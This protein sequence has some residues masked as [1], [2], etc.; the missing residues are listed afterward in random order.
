M[1]PFDPNHNF[2]MSALSKVEV[3]GIPVM[4]SLNSF[5]GYIQFKLGFHCT[6]P[7][8]MSS[9]QLLADWSA[10]A[11]GELPPTWRSLLH[12]IRQLGLDDLG[13]EIE[14]YLKSG[15]TKHDPKGED[16][17]SIMTAESEK[18]NPAT[19]KLCCYVY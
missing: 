4:S 5:Y 10:R 15:R 17:K 8:N 2:T 3:A 9:I 7:H 1:T 12:I 11:Q 6:T 16:G 13:F 19:V 14:A 18:F